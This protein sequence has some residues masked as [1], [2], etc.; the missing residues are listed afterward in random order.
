M[1]TYSKCVE[2]CVKRGRKKLAGN[3][4]LIRDGEK[5]IVEFWGS[6]II[7]IHQ[8]GTY[9]VSACG[10]KTVTTKARI[11]EYTP[12]GIY[13]KQFQWYFR[14]G[15]EF[16][17]EW[18]GY[19]L[20]PSGLL[21]HVPPFVPQAMRAHMLDNRSDAGSWAVCADWCEENGYPEAAERCREIYHELS[22]LVCV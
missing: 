17:A 20:S 16:G 5:F 10:H 19:L 9:T 21:M 2:L 4:W 22:E 7:T 6:P 15:E 12:A 14:N 13:Q 3:T 8:D 1:L 18:H 11:N